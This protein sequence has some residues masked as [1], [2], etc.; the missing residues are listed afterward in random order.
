MFG[1]SA[2]MHVFRG[3]LIELHLLGCSGPIFETYYLD[4]RLANQKSKKN[5]E[6]TTLNRSLE[7]TSLWDHSQIKEHRTWRSI[8][9]SRALYDQM[10]PQLCLFYVSARTDFSSYR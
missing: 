5:A 6:T 4:F 9:K 3:P 8:A 2:R 1:I 10:A 7:E